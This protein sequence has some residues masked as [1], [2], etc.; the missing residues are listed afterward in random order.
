MS[1]PSDIR[2]LLMKEYMERLRRRPVHPMMTEIKKVRNKVITLKLKAARRKKSPLFLSTEL[3]TVLK[4]I[5]TGKA[6]DPN[7]GKRTSFLRDTNLDRGIC[8]MRKML[9]VVAVSQLLDIRPTHK[10]L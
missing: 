2:K 5:K 7:K 6:R 9:K 10:A 8:E 1:A 3:E 4:T